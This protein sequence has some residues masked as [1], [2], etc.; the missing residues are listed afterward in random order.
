MGYSDN[1]WRRI[2]ALITIMGELGTTEEGAHSAPVRLTHLAERAGRDN[3]LG[4]STI[5]QL[6]RRTEQVGL[7]ETA[8][9]AHPQGDRRNRYVRLT[10]DGLIALGGGPID[11]YRTRANHA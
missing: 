4:R 8:P 7:I 3:N 1:T 2:S 5:Y 9:D 10:A 6:I 11:A